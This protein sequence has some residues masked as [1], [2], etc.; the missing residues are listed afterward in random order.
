MQVVRKIFLNN[1]TISFITLIINKY[2]NTFL[3]L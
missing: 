2:N 1:T 3:S